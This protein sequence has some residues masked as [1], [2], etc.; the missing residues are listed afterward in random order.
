MEITKISITLFLVITL[1]ISCHC[2]V[3][4]EPPVSTTTKY[5]ECISENFC[6]VGRS[7]TRECIL[8]CLER[9]IKYVGGDCVPKSPQYGY[10]CC[11]IPEPEI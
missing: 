9:G 10:C 3:L 1:A 8:T 4:T 6:K 11:I 5:G 2:N 7:G